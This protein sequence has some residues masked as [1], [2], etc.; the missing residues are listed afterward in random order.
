MLTFFFGQDEWGMKSELRK[1]EAGFKEKDLGDMNIVHLEGQ[2]LSASNLATE[3]MTVG[4]LTPKKLI[5]IENL[6]SNKST[7]QLEKIVK[8]L[9]QENSTCD[10]VIMET[11]KPDKRTV[12]FKELSKIA[13]P[14]EFVLPDQFGLTQRIL[15]LVKKH[16]ATITKPAAALLSVMVPNDSLRLEQ[17]IIKLAT[18]KLNAEINEADVADMVVSEV[19]SDVF[20]FVESLANKRLE[21]SLK[22]LSKLIQTGQNENYILT[23]IVW[24]YRQ[25]L[26]VRNLV[27]Q[28]KATAGNAG[29]N[30]YSFNKTLNISKKYSFSE[31]KKIYKQ[32]EDYDFYMKTGELSPQI[33]LELL[34]THLC[35]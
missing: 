9:K 18:Y 33:A 34:A 3:L 25:A 31:L 15:E 22:A 13:K 21:Q 8:L 24:Q 6:L 35:G 28:K 7:D 14:R 2:T 29:I 27:D 10:V 19:S 4:F 17:E 32:L 1:I 30:P 26:L 12:A 5:I 16:G 20:E 23:M 11:L